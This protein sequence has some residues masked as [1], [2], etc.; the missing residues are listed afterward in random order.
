M[1][2]DS[3]YRKQKNVLGKEQ[4]KEKFA[5]EIHDIWYRNF[6]GHMIKGNLWESIKISKKKVEEIRESDDLTRRCTI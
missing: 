2:E 6:K 4:P 3:N 1:R 5:K